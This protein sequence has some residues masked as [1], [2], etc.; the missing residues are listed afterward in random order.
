ML[1][2]KMTK[3]RVL[4]LTPPRYGKKPTEREECCFGEVDTVEFPCHLVSV[5]G[6]I[7]EYTDTIVFDANAEN[8]G[9]EDIEK[10][11]IELKPEFVIYSILTFYD[12][13]E[14]KVAEICKKHNVKCIGMPCPMGYAKDMT[15]YPFYFVTTTEPE[16]S[17]IDFFKGT[18]VEKLKGIVYRKGNKIIN[19]K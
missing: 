9:F 12:D 5:A 11:I 19:T 3:S 17:F 1:V 15:K 2:K 8:K 7:R 6:A 10:R 4:L 16:K 14:A 13:Y 18:P